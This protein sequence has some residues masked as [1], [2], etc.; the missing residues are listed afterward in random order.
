VDPGG[1][2]HEQRG[3]REQRQRGRLRQRGDRR[4]GR[5]AQ[6]EDELVLEHDRQVRLEA[7]E[8]ER[9]RAADQEFAPQV[10][11][12]VD[13]G[14]GAGGVDRVVG[15]ID[16]FGI[17]AVVSEQRIAHG[18]DSEAQLR[19]EQRIHLPKLPGAGALGEGPQVGGST[20][21]AAGHIQVGGTAADLVDLA[22]GG[23]VL[24]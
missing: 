2:E 14:A 24:Q 9:G 1:D 4:I 3:G 10:A 5:G 11:G 15:L 22:R 12:G 18:P 16:D 19:R 7:R 13:V 21:Q 17:E 8:R 23:R 20:R 6:A